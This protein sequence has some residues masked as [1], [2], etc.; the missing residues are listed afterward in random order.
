MPA[1]KRGRELG[2]ELLTRGTRGPAVVLFFGV[3]LGPPQFH[4]L[5]AS[6]I[7]VVERLNGFDTFWY[8]WS[9]NNPETEVLQ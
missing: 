5:L 4:G 1:R 8:N 6:Y 9:L 2:D 7:W 3:L